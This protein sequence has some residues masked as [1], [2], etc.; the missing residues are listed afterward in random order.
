MDIATV[1]TRFMDIQMYNVDGKEI[2]LRFDARLKRYLEEDKPL[3]KMFEAARQVWDGNNDVYDGSESVLSVLQDYDYKEQGELD[4][5]IR[6]WIFDYEFTFSDLALTNFFSADDDIPVWE[7]TETL[8]GDPRGYESIIHK[9]A[10]DNGINATLNARVR[11]VEGIERNFIK[12]ILNIRL[13][14]LDV[15]SLL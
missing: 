11:Y 14:L 6:W 2:P 8:V 15:F 7:E 10:D 4:A 1:Q 5:Y 9:I 13:L 3:Y 12:R